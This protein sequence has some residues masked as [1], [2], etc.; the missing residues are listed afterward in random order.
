M[1]EDASVSEGPGVVARVVLV[2]VLVWVPGEVPD[3]DFG[4]SSCVGFGMGLSRPGLKL[5]VRLLSLFLCCWGYCLAPRGL[6]LFG[7]KPKS[8]VN[9]STRS[10]FFFQLSGP[11]GFHL[12]HPVTS[13]CCCVCLL[14]LFAVVSLLVSRFVSPSSPCRCAVSVCHSLSP[15]VF[16][17][18][19]V[20]ALLLDVVA[21]F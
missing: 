19:S 15:L 9:C 17:L 12:H 6:I 11:H 16:L 10:L 18:V 21:A 14:S 5:D 1:C 4:A 8:S 3:G 7:P 13:P 20:P 2:W